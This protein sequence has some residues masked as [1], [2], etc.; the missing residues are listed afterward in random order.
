MQAFTSVKRGV[1]KV[2]E[3]LCIAILA[4]MTVLVTYQV[5]TRY[6]F[7][8]PSAI[9][10]ALAQYLFVWMIMYGSAYVFGL[11]E[12]LDITVVKDKLTG[13]PMLIVELL[14]NAVLIAFAVAVLLY[15]GYAV[16]AQQMG[17]MDAALQIPMGVIYS[18]IPIS[19]VFILFYAIYNITLAFHDYKAGKFDT[20]SSSDPTAGTM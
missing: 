8:K 19:G 11:K 2:I 6:F 16:T 10:E 13:V 4:I 3:W 15:G 5:V 17:T 7:N 18:A 14:I 12:H 1:D 9:S 20:G